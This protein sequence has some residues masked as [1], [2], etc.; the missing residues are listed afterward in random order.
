MNFFASSGSIM[1]HFLV[2]QHLPP[3]SGSLRCLFSWADN[4]INDYI[5]RGVFIEHKIVQKT[6]DFVYCIS[7]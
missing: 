2:R 7:G 1:G 4:H 6:P 5:P 3:F